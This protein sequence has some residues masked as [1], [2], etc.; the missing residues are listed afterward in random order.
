MTE[1]KLQ[2]P[3]QRGAKLRIAHD[4]LIMFIGVVSY[5]FGWTAFILSQNITSGG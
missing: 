5:A 2:L 1:S 4:L 3:K